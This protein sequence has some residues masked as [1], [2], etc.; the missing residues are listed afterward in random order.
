MC[1]FPYRSVK[2]RRFFL[3]DSFPRQSGQTKIFTLCLLIFFLY[4]TFIF[5]RPLCF[6]KEHQKSTQLYTSVRFK[7]IHKF[8]RE[9]NSQS[10]S[11]DNSFLKS[12]KKERP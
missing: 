4:N 9:K 2:Q 1:I 8:L 5:V 6:V 10:L 3:M 12:L 11:S 7:E